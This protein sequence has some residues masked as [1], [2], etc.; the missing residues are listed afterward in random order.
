M[1]KISTDA[2]FKKIRSRIGSERGDLIAV[3]KE[4]VAE[5]SKVD[6]MLAL[7]SDKFDAAALPYGQHPYETIATAS[8]VRVK[9][10]DNPGKKNK[11]PVT[12]SK[13]EE[14]K[15]SKILRLLIDNAA[16][17][18][19]LKDIHIKTGFAKAI[20]PALCRLRTRGLIKTVRFRTSGFFWYM[21]TEKAI[22][23]AE[24]TGLVP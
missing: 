9:S 12:K 6:S 3:R 2:I 21:P 5:L 19:S 15:T 23:L 13:D 17:G 7:L 14:T 1:I 10:E 11:K 4:L 8:V 22:E 24:K 18:L 16:N 20:S